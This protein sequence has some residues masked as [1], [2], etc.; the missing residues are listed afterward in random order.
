VIGAAGAI[1]VLGG[2]GSGGTYL[3][4]VYVSA[5]GGAD[6]TLLGRH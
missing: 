1:Y 5:D 6:R 3:N 4:N 2:Y